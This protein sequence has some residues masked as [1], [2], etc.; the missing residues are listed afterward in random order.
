M[1][2]RIASERMILQRH[3][4]NFASRRRTALRRAQSSLPV[5][6]SSHNSLIR[7]RLGAVDPALQD[8]KAISLGLTAPKIDGILIRPGEVFSF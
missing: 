7:R 1:T 6:V 8:N 5:L 3:V 4:Q 2:H